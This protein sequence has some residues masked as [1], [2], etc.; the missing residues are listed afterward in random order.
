VL[1]PSAVNAVG[2]DVHDNDGGVMQLSLTDSTTGLVTTFDFTSVAGSNKTEFFGVIF[3]STTFISSLRVSGTD[4]GGVTSW[5]NFT[6]GVGENAVVPEPTTLAIFALGM[7]G[8]VS[9]RFK[10]QS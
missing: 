1:F 3:D 10:K 6:T 7:I 5:D 9:R 2:F 8:L 4:P